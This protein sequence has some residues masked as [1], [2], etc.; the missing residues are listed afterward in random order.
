MA[1]EKV[2]DDELIRLF[3]AVLRDPLPFDTKRW[4][5][6]QRW[7]RLLVAEFPLWSFQAWEYTRLQGKDLP[8][9]FP[10]QLI[11]DSIL[12]D[13]GISPQ[14]ALE[15]LD[16]TVDRRR[17]SLGYERGDLIEYPLD[18]AQL[19]GGHAEF[20]C[21]PPLFT[22]ESE[23]EHHYDPR[24]SPYE[25][26]GI[27]LVGLIEERDRARLAGDRDALADAVAGLKRLEK[28]ISAKL[29]VGN[30][31][32][33]PPEE[34]LRALVQEGRRLLGLCWEVCPFEL[35][36]KADSVLAD[37]GIREEER[38]VWA[39]QL[40]LPVL[41][42]LEISVLGKQIRL[43]RG[44]DSR[45][46]GRPT[47]RRMAVWIVAHRLGRDAS[48]IARKAGGGSGGAAEEFPSVD[49]PFQTP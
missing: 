16:Y 7:F 3:A 22:E 34:I 45:V 2:S 13:D 14:S 30:P 11:I 27:E 9:S 28:H 4:S 21:A 39:I 17:R 40:A 38:W 41:S 49:D 23:S 31:G 20:Y 10:L 35:S 12:K 26:L 19:P 46:V 8:S 24:T 18:E 15:P 32:I 48:A 36:D 43:A 44:R 42:R 6:L 29:G 33:D 37:H 1:N 5:N 25:D 47:P